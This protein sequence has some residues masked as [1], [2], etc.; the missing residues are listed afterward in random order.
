MIVPRTPALM[1]V[2]LDDSLAEMHSAVLE[3]ADDASRA[4]TGLRGVAIE[5]G[6]PVRGVGTE[7]VAV[8]DAAVPRASDACSRRGEGAQPA[9]LDLGERLASVPVEERACAPLLMGED[10]PPTGTAFRLRL[11][12]R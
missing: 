7:V 11:G 9:G 5:M 6:M 3:G 10:F 2:V 8:K 4:T 1:A 12:R